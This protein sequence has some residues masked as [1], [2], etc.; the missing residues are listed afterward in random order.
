MKRLILI[1]MIITL[2]SLTGC[3][4]DLKGSGIE[5][6]DNNSREVKTG[7][8]RIFSKEF[9]I[10][11]QNNLKVDLNTS[12]GEINLSKTNDK[13]FKGDIK[14]NI[15]EIKPRIDLR[16]D[17]LNIGYYNTKKITFGIGK[18]S[19]FINKWDLK[20]T[21]KLPLSIDIEANATKS[22]YDLTDLMVE[23][24]TTDFNA[25]D[26]DIY[27]NEKNKVDL[28]N[29]EI[30]TNAGNVEV[31]GLSNA[32]AKDID[33]DVNAG[34]ASID[35]DGDINY[36]VEM[37]ISVNV[38]S[39]SLELPNN[40]GIFIRKDSQ[41][42]SLDIHGKDL[43]KISSNEFKTTNYDDKK[44]KIDITIEG[45]ASSINIK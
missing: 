7:D 41:L 8:L 14:T 6:T 19:N 18:P 39:I 22:I 12:A 13:L 3:V 4:I 17:N 21:N 31:N 43:E 24:F 26:V 35:F 2:L 33:V 15:V 30:E 37:D 10:K 1:I 44:H 36:D 27:F 23:E 45:N 29:L 32:R 40:A 9:D 38:G 25:S 20:L 5:I 28:D 11:G 34:N 16:D 42:L